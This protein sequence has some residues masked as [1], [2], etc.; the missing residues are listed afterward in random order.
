MDFTVKIEG[1]DEVQR[2]L[3]LLP[4]RMGRNAMRRALRRGANIMR[5]AARA[6][7]KRFDDPATREAIWRNVVVKGMARRQ[8][9]SGGFIG[10]K[11][12][13]LGGARDMRKYGET[14]GKGKGNPGGDTFH[15]RFLE[16][17][18][19]KM[20][21][22][23]FMRPAMENSAGKVFAETAKAMSEQLDKELAKIK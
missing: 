8:E 9:R 4:E 10:M 15:W 18:T 21:A 12:G 2:K 17:G 3:K 11:V 16:F 23:P 7:A 13:I 22:Q 19:S 14:K 6:N 5:D 20:G 1:L